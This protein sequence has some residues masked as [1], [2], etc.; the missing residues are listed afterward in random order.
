MTIRLTPGLPDGDPDL[1]GKATMYRLMV[2]NTIDVIIRYDASR[3]RT[4]VSPSSREM[5]GYEPEEM[6][7]ANASS[8]IHPDDFPHVNPLYRDISPDRT[9]LH[10]TFRMLR[11]DGV[12]IWVENRYR[13]LPE[14]GGWLAVMRDVTARKR[15]EEM[16]AD[17]NARLETANQRLQ[18]LA[19]QDGLTGLMN[20][21][22]FDEL[23]EEEFRRARRHQV[24]LGVLLLDV[25]HFKGYNDHYGHLAGDEC[26]R[27]L[28]R[29]IQSVLRRAGD[30][31]ARYGGEEFVVILPATNR[32]GA[33]VAGERIRA[34]VAAMAIEHSGSALG[35]VTVSVGCSSMIP[36]Y[37]EEISMNL[38]AAA[39]RALYQAKSEG[40]NRVAAPAVSCS[41]QSAE[42]EGESPFFVI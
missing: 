18:A 34:A 8:L 27:R 24:P 10:L 36:S 15:V 17:A 37:N 40:R 25:D 22:R 16:L 41:G 21:R 26:L 1:S 28:S 2:E 13:Y 7:G 31:V 12:Y 23:F 38:I 32:H 30:H 6:L 11:K 19:H 29:T 9:D 42:T 5:L 20:R 33:M 3:V 14:D 4:Y 39:D 35:I